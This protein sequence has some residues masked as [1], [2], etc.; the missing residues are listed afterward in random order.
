MVG[1]YSVSNSEVLIW[2]VDAQKGHQEI[3]F[4]ID[5]NTPINPLISLLTYLL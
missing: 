3:E 2:H 4:T 1:T 5:F